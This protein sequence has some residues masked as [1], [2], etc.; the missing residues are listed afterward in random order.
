MPRLLAQITVGHLAVLA[1]PTAAFLN[2][3]ASVAFSFSQFIKILV[4]KME[5]V[6]FSPGDFCIEEGEVGHE[7]YFLSVGRVSVIANQTHLATRG[8]G[9]CIGEI[10]LLLPDVVRTASIVAEVFCEAHKLTREDFRFCLAD[11]VR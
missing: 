10:A 3:T 2:A 9:D 4:S 11:F 8:C 1:H 6:V 7:V 5:H